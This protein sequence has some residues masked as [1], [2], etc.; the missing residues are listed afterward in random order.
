YMP[1]ESTPGWALVTVAQTTNARQQL[2]NDMSIKVW[3]LILLMSVL[4]IGASGLAIRRGLRPL[5][6]IGTIIAARD[7]ADLR[8]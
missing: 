4:A 3:T 5:A 2:T 7:P 8:P 1:E 6:Q